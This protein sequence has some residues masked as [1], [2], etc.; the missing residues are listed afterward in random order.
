MGTNKNTE[1]PRL[2]GPYLSLPKG[3]WALFGAILINRMGNFVAPFLTLYL[4]QKAGY[5]AAQTGLF[6]MLLPL[7]VIP[8]LLGGGWMADHWGRRRVLVVGQALAGSVYVVASLGPQSPMVPVLLVAATFLANVAQVAHNAMLNDL[9]VPENRKTAFSLNYLG[10]N[11]GFSIG[12]LAAGLLFSTNLGLFFLFDGLSTW[13]SAALVF[14][15]TRETL[16][17]APAAAEAEGAPG[18]RPVAGSLFKVLFQRPYFLWFLAIGFLSN[19]V[20]GQHTFSLPLQ[21][22]QDF[23]PSGGPGVFGLLMAVNGL[24]V[25]VGSTVLTRLT[26]R[27][28]SLR[29]V[30]GATLLYGAGFG[31]IG[32]IGLLPGPPLGWFVFSTVL[33]TLGEILASVAGHVYVAG[34]TPANH[35]GRFN[36]VRMVTWNLSSALATAGAGL[37]VQ[38]L[39]VTAIWPA[40]AAVALA[41]CGALVWL[42]RKEVTCPEGSPG[43]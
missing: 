43:P 8:G 26:A 29:V 28:P 30:A 37:Y 41:A 13:A 35:R 2:L 7:A 11:L 1:G 31:M 22:N 18:E 5:S 39:G 4:T 32:A 15:L 9:T 16:H 19:A 36:S 21:L 12:P 10:I 3:I 38:A 14:F 17:D 33:W 23:G 27:F 24:T 42:H 40:V 20:Y 6:L 25:V 34:H